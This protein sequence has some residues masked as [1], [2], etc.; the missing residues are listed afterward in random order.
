MR[1]LLL[2]PLRQCLHALLL[3]PCKLQANGKVRSG[4]DYAI[5]VVVVVAAV[6]SGQC[7]EYTHVAVYHLHGIGGIC[8][9]AML[10]LLLP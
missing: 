8:N 9:Y 7:I 6:A 10:P 5:F 4:F 3:L 1:W 2:L